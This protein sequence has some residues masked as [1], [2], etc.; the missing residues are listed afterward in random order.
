MGESEQK[1]TLHPEFQVLQCFRE[2]TTVSV[3]SI[4]NDS[5]LRD[6]HEVQQKSEQLQ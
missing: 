3:G 5:I 4:G 2:V 1:I 6:V